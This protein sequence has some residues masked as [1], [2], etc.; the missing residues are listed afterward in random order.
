MKI[1]GVLSLSAIIIFPCFADTKIVFKNIKTESINLRIEKV[2]QVSGFSTDFE[3][4]FITSEGT[5]LD[6]TCPQTKVPTKDKA[7]I[8]FFNK[9]HVFVSAF[10]IKDR[11]V[12]DQFTEHIN[13]IQHRVDPLNPILIRLSRTKK[14][15]EY[16]ELPPIDPYEIYSKPQ[17]GKKVIANFE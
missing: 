5:K 16:L 7:Y 3:W 4:E 10:Y 1:F 8:N 17:A 11:R 6:F 15:V 2:R 14:S 13:G 12:C 9:D